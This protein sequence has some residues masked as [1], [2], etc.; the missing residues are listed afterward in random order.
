MDTWL[1]A[2]GIGLP[3]SAQSICEGRVFEKRRARA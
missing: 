1:S 3:L 2:Q